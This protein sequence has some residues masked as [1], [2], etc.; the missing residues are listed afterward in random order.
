MCRSNQAVLRQAM[1]KYKI[2]Q[3]PRKI[4]LA[5]LEAVHSD[6]ERIAQSVVSPPINQLAR[7]HLTRYFVKQT[8]LVTYNKE[9]H[10]QI[11]DQVIAEVLQSVSVQTV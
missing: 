9:V 4:T 7:F 1:G 2:H 3:D 6:I 11:Y 5:G 10:A 8:L